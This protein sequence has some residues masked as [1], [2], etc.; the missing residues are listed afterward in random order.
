MMELS[1][2][3]VRVLTL[4]IQAMS[5]VRLKLRQSIIT[6]SLMADGVIV[7][8]AALVQVSL[9]VYI[10]YIRNSE[11]IVAISINEFFIYFSCLM[12]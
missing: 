4:L 1:I 12:I 7:R 6:R 11:H 5:G 9:M 10:L 2:M 8:R 3:N